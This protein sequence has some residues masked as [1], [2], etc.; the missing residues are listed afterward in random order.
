MPP[1]VSLD[2]VTKE[3]SGKQL[4]G[5]A[6]RIDLPG[7]DTLLFVGNLGPDFTDADLVE[8]FGKHGAIYR[9]FVR[10]VPRNPIAYRA[11]P[12]CV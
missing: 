2:N 9:S 11:V 6:V 5:K 8:I 4:R 10:I 12:R 1:G 3:L 7:V